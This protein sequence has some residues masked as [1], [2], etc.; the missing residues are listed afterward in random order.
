MSTPTQ[1]Q[2]NEPTDS[3]IFDKLT[4]VGP[5]STNERFETY[6]IALETTRYEGQ[7]LWQIF[8]VFLAIHTLFSGF[9]LNAA[10]TD[11]PLSFSPRIFVACL[12]GLALCWPWLASYSRNVAHYRYHLAHARVL[13]PE[14][15]DLYG[16][17]G[18][19]FSMGKAVKVGFGSYRLGWSARRVRSGRM[20]PP[21]I[22]IFVIFYLTLLFYSGPWRSPNSRQETNAVG[23][24][25]SA[26]PSRAQA[27]D[28]HPK[29]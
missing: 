27:P 8:S 20:I 2:I 6:K 17:A 9:L 12:I 23:S 26:E 14:G 11:S 21:V 4:Q 13:E 24:I 1:S 29:D 10:L 5:P 19:D 28:N 7:L 22:L 25:L 3:D 16:G 18:R 15:W